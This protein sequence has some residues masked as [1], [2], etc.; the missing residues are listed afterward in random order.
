MN[1]LQPNPMLRDALLL[2]GLLSGVTG[3]LLVLAW[4]DLLRLHMIPALILAL[5]V[6]RG[7]GAMYKGEPSK[8]PVRVISCVPPS[9]SCSFFIFATPKSSNLTVISPASR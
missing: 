2:D 7:L 3:L 4:Q 6:W 9:W 8:V 1:V 5:I